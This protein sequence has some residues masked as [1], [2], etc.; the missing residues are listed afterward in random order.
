MHFQVH[1]FETTQA[2]SLGEGIKGVQQQRVTI[3]WWTLEKKDDQVCR[4]PRT[5][6]SEAAARSHI[7]S[8]KTAMKGASR[9]K[10]LSP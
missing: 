6:D 2:V 7:A 8:A 3:Y 5:F 4:A 9:C 1:K 10:V